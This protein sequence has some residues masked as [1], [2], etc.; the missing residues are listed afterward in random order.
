[1]AGLVALVTVGQVVIGKNLEPNLISLGVLAYILYFINK[2][3]KKYKKDG[4]LVGSEKL[5]VI[6]TEALAPILAQSFY[7]YCWRNEL[8]MKAKQANRY[9]WIVIGIEILIG[10]AFVVFTAR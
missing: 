8:P 7:Y 9:G 2:I 6:V 1:M 5:Q 10:I 4:P 3:E